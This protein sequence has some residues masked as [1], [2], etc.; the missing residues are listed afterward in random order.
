MKP[1]YI[2][3]GGP[4][5]KD[6]PFHLLKGQR[7]WAINSSFL[8]LEFAPE[9]ILWSDLS[10]PLGFSEDLLKDLYKKGS[11]LIEFVWLP[12][13]NPSMP[14]YIDQVA[15]PPNPGN[16]TGWHSL[17]W[18][19]KLGEKNIRLLGFDGRNDP[20]TGQKHYHDRDPDSESTDEEM[21][22]YWNDHWSKLK[23]PPRTIV[24]NYSPITKIDTFIIGNLEGLI[25]NLEKM[26]DR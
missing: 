21:D 20:E 9:A 2:L 6:F 26:N 13:H 15:L 5:L 16:N 19:L 18:A 3:G 8:D 23:P 10:F 17:W 25:E 12:D 24:V 7:V 4:S 22:F 14:S 11:H 1:L